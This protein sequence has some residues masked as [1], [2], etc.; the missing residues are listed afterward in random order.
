MPEPAT[1]RPPRSRF[2]LATLATAVLLWAP[3]S[4]AAISIEIVGIDAELRRN[5][6]VFLS[7]ARFQD[8]RELDEETILRLHDRVEREVAA[9]LRPF[10]YYESQVRSTLTPGEGTRNWRVRIE[11]TPGRPVM[12]TDVEFGINGAGADEPAFVDISQNSSLRV[13]SQLRHGDYDSLKGAMQR[14]AATLGYLDAK[15]VKSELR[16]DAANYAARAALVMET[17]PRYRFGVTTIEQ[18]VIDER[19]FR[20]YLRF[21]ENEPFNGSDLLRTQFAL[22]DSQYFANVEVLPGEANRETLAVP[23]H[24]RAGAN[25]RQRY[26]YGAGYGTD[27]QVR[28]TFSWENRRVNTRG[29]RFR[30]EVKAASQD[31]SLTA[32]YLI[33][34]GDPALEKLTLEASAV[35]ADRADLDTTSFSLQPSVTE[36]RGRWQRVLFAIGTR[37]TTKTIGAA[38][39][40]RQTDTLL[41]PGI[42]YASVPQGYLGEALFTRALYAELRGS[43]NA[44]GSDSDFLQLRVEGERVF[45]LARS[46]HLLLRGQLGASAVA[47]FSSLPGS[48]RFFAG[49]DR[50][51]RGYGYNELSPLDENGLKVGGKHLLTGTAEVVRDLPRNFAIAVFAD[52]GNAMDDFGTALKYSAGIGVRWKLP[53][54]TVGIDVAQPLSDLYRLDNASGQLRKESQGPRLHINFSPKL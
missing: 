23:V 9:S 50:S 49:G 45:D 47:D 21:R 3:V 17:G 26:Q 19:L 30:T 6:L 52:A 37:T 18:N 51:V 27:T 16:V 48:Q 53:V 38:T 46:W 33:P 24:I 5:V 22:D 25:R 15:L 43:H 39:A 1:A 13:G 11:I 20:K 36:I 8:S 42:S 28:G 34:F 41:I 29:H 54:V 7:L 10:G 12:L 31:R 14:T 35:T 2:C 32:R 44:L 40:L 4:Y